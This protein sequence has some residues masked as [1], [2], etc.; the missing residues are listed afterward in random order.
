MRFNA[1]HCLTCCHCHYRSFLGMFAHCCLPMLLPLDALC[2]SQSHL[3]SRVQSPGPFKPYNSAFCLVIM[4]LTSKSTALNYI[5]LS[6]SPYYIS[7]AKCRAER[8]REVC[9][10]HQDPTMT[11][12]HVPAARIWNSFWIFQKVSD[13]HPGIANSRPSPIHIDHRWS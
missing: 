12:C 13:K 6:L 4:Q 9:L 8:E 11:L 2:Q 7:Y 1:W 5:S 10:H 3:P